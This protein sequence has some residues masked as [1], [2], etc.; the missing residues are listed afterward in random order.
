LGLREDTPILLFAGRLVHEKNPIFTVDVLVELLR[1]E[2]DVVAVFAGTGALA[3]VILAK[4]R[5]FGVESAVRFLGWRSDIPAVMKCCDWFI[6]PRPEHP[7]EGFGI[8]VVEA[9]L[10][11]LRMLLSK[12]IADDPLLPTAKFRRLALSDGPKA[13]AA[14]AVALRNGAAPSPAAAVEALKDSPMDMSRA[15]NALMELYT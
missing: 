11:G 15:F 1:I 8:A 14:A 9:Q 2:P 6:L 3:P 10:A 13:W 4:A 5:E 7:M 12:G